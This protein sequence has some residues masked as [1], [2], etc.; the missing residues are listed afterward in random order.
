[1]QRIPP[2]AAQ[3]TPVAALGFRVQR[4]KWAIIVCL[5]LGEIPGRTIFMLKGMD[6]A[7][8]PSF[9]LTNTVQIG[10]QDL[11]RHVAERFSTHNLIVRLWHNVLGTGLHIIGISYSRIAR[12]DVA[13]LRLAAK[14]IADAE[15]IVFKAIQD[16]A[17]DATIDHANGWMVSS[18]ETGDIYS[19]HEPQICILTR[20][21][22]SASICIMRQCVQCAL[23]FPPNSHKEKKCREEEGETTAGARACKAHC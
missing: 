3:K 17:I 7:L 5:L 8:R 2:A 14:P 20:G 12:T 19:T 23:R 6:Q 11:F 15:S 21:L 13:K 16:G 18:K 9:E 10:D 4:N 22:L 1:M